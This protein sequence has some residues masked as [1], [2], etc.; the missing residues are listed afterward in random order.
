MMMALEVYEL[1]QKERKMNRSNGCC[2]KCS[3][4]YL[5]FIT[6]ALGIF[7]KN[8]IWKYS[9]FIYYPTRIAK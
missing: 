8:N 7:N 1:F 9:Q 4:K 5:S 6:N 2:V 3:N